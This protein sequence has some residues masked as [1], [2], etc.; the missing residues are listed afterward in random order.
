MTCS[1][2]SLLYV[3][4]DVVLTA[5]FQAQQLG[6]LANEAGVAMAHA[7]QGG[8]GGGRLRVFAEV[9]SF[10]LNWNSFTFGSMSHNNL[11]FAKQ[12][13]RRSCKQMAAKLNC[14]AVPD[15]AFAPG[16]HVPGGSSAHHTASSTRTPVHYEKATARTPSRSTSRMGSCAA[17]RGKAIQEPQDTDDSD[18]QSDSRDEDPDFEVLRMSQMFDAPPGSQTQ[19]ESSQVHFAL[20]HC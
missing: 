5:L 12:R 10:V 15:Q 13:V 17:S 1:Y 7:S 3:V 20:I 6:R 9:S 18:E 14:M 8:N 4:V 11:G 2:N 16:A 19:G